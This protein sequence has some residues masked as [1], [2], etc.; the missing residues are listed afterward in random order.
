MGALIFSWPLVL[1]LCDSCGRHKLISLWRLVLPWHGFFIWRWEIT[2]RKDVGSKQS[3]FPLKPFLHLTLRR[4]VKPTNSPAGLRSVTSGFPPGYSHHMLYV[5]GRVTTMQQ[6]PDLGGHSREKR[7]HPDDCS[8]VTGWRSPSPP[9]ISC[10]PHKFWP[11]VNMSLEKRHESAWW[12]EHVFDQ[13]LTMQFFFLHK[14]TSFLSAVEDDLLNEAPAG[15]ANPKHP[16]C[17]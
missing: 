7:L 8:R 13:L 6:A 3:S 15:K 9:L 5:L 16:L 17:Q 11:G 1:C 4:Q 14:T 12:S 10:P 2:G